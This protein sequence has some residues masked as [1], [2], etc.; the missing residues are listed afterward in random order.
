[1]WLASYYWIFSFLLWSA[2]SG[3]NVEVQ[4]LAASVSKATSSF[5]TTQLPSIEATQFA[6][7]DGAE[8][9]SI[10]S[11]MSQLEG[12][13]P[14]APSKYGYMTVVVG[15][16]AQGQKIIGMQASSNEVFQGS[17]ARIPSNTNLATKDVIATYIAGLSTV[18]AVLPLVERVG[19]SEE[20]AMV[21]GKVVVMGG[22]DL[23]CF[24]A[25]GLST[26]GAHVCLVS[27]GSPRVRPPDSRGTNQ[28]VGKG[29]S[30]RVWNVPLL[31]A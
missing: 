23:A 8:W 13:V 15:K 19:G 9:A 24:A 27:T 6:L 31:Q 16:D 14:W 5:P 17:V 7:L 10:Q 29:A 25:E 3:R 18:H 20:T 2:T 30:G 21:G 11:I 4:A 1:M 28:A 22:N 12:S 26:L